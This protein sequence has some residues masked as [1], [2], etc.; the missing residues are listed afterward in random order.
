[1][2]KVPEVLYRKWLKRLK[3]QL[4]WICPF[5]TFVK[6]VFS[7]GSNYFVFPKNINCIHNKKQAKEVQIIYR[8]LLGNCYL[9]L[10]F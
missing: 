9:L 7:N 5:F 2:L 1:M 10:S 3:S 6:Y 8:L 4:E